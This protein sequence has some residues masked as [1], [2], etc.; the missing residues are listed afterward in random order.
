[1]PLLQT[2][3][4]SQSAGFTYSPFGIPSQSNSNSS[5]D[6]SDSTGPLKAITEISTAKTAYI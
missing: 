2:T 5:D 3:N 4:D 1:M 6:S